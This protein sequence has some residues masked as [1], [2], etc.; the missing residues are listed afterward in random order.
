MECYFNE[1]ANYED[2]EELVNVFNEEDID[3]RIRLDKELTYI[4][5]EDH[6]DYAQEFIRNHGKRKMSKDKVYWF[7][8]LVQE[9]VKTY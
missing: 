8:E 1:S 6:V 9:N 2:L 3:Y 4:L 5:N 7:I